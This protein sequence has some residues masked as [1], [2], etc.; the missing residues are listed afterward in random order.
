MSTTAQKPPSSAA[1]TFYNYVKDRTLGTTLMVSQREIYEYMLTQ[2]FC[3]TWSETQ[4]QH[5]DHCRTLKRL[6]DEINL[7]ARTDKLIYQ[8]GWMYCI[9]NEEQAQAIVDA[10][11]EKALTALHRESVVAQKMNRDGQGKIVNNRDLAMKPGNEEFHEAYNKPEPKPVTHSIRVNVK[12]GEYYGWVHFIK[13]V[14]EGAD[15]ESL[16]KDYETK[17]LKRGQE[18]QSWEVCK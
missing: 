9:A 3:L 4:N 14:P 17:S 10:Y 11:H 8:K 7:N 18:I 2:G 15:D 13:N 5:N 6:L 12:D 16:V 1:W